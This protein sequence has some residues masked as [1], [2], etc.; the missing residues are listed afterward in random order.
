V[1]SSRWGISIRPSHGGGDPRGIPGPVVVDHSFL[2]PL[3]PL[4]STLF[5]AVGT[6][7]LFEILCFAVPILLFHQQMVEHKQLLL[8]EADQLRYE[9]ISVQR[10]LLQE[11]SGNPR[12][13]SI[14]TE[15]L[16]AL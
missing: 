4:A 11:S 14:H 3:S 16:K 1:A 8:V 7:L 9:I 15:Q 6:A 5:L 12:I 13:W 10:H 2:S